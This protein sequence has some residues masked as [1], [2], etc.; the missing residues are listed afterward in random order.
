METRVIRSR[1]GC[2]KSAPQLQLLAVRE[3]LRVLGANMWH[4]ALR[5]IS[6]RSAA[7]NLTLKTGFAETQQAKHYWHS[8]SMVTV[9]AVGLNVSTLA[10]CPCSAGQCLHEP[11]ELSLVITVDIVAIIRRMLG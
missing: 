5:I 4:V 6:E 3:Q 10:C 8:R 7:L 1:P 2:R 9:D 11:L